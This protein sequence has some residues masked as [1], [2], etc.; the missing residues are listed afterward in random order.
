MLGF[1]S[2]YFAGVGL[3][4]NTA[5]LP[6]LMFG[7]AV[8][9][10]F[11][12][13]SEE[14]SRTNDSPTLAGAVLPLRYRLLRLMEI[15]RSGSLVFCPLH[16]DSCPSPPIRAE[17][18]KPAGGV[19][20]PQQTPA[21]RANTRGAGRYYPRTLDVFARWHSLEACENWSLS[22]RGGLAAS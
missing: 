4:S 8:L 19:R 14:L 16:T 10:A 11:L 21:D 18:S 9:M 22:E 13:H 17:Q 2:G 6:L 7:R 15:V 3:A 12:Q 1:S 20:P 5:G